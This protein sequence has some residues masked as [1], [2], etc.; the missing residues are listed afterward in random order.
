MLRE[1]VKANRESKIQGKENET[2]GEEFKVRVSLLLY[3]RCDYF[4]HL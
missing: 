1:E 4:S 3:Q 2:K